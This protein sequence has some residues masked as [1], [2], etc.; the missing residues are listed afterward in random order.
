MNDKQ[1]N[2]L[3][4]AGLLHAAALETESFRSVPFEL[5]ASY[6]RWEVKFL[7]DPFRLSKKTARPLWMRIARTVAVLFLVFTLFFGALTTVSPSA[8]AWVQRI[9]SHTYKEYTAYHFADSSVPASTEPGQMGD[10]RPGWLPEGYELV[11]E[12]NSFEGHV[13]RNYQNASGNSISIDY[14]P[15]TSNSTFNVNSEHHI[16]SIV[17]IGDKSG[18]LIG[19]TMPDY[20]SSLIWVDPVCNIA[21]LICGPLSDFELIRIAEDMTL[22]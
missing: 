22:S 11:F 17:Q 2:N 19:S 15:A 12:F 21:F 6:R 1:L 14:M 4:C 16:T 18:Y 5:S 10:W 9:F 7:A 8:R 13:Q 20:D 3:L